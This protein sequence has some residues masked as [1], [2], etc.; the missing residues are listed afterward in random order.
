MSMAVPAFVLLKVPV[1]RSS[2]PPP[3]LI[4]IVLVPELTLAPAPV[5]AFPRTIG[6]LVVVT[7]PLRVVRDGAVAV[8]PPANELVPPDVPID[9]VPVFENVLAPVMLLEAPFNATL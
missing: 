4:L 3:A 5:V 7:V 8:K 6:V 9:S 1:P 2:A